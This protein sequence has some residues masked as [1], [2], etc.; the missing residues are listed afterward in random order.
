MDLQLVFQL[1]QQD[2]KDGGFNINLNWIFSGFLLRKVALA[3]LITFK[4]FHSAN[5]MHGFHG[6][7]GRPESWFSLAV[8]SIRHY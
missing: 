8:F 1:V 4:L 6:F 5:L 7:N 2:G 3:Q